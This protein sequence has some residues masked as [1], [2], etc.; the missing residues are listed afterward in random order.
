MS[1]YMR[2]ITDRQ[3]CVSPRTTNYLR[4][5]WFTYFR[6]SRLAGST[7]RWYSAS[8]TVQLN[9]GL[10]KLPHDRRA[11]RQHMSI[12]TCCMPSWLWLAFVWFPIITSLYWPRR[13]KGAC[14]PARMPTV[15][16]NGLERLLRRDHRGRHSTVKPSTAMTY[17]GYIEY[18]SWN[19]SSKY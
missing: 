6:R 15:T 19:D 14:L 7:S 18:R 17:I 1:D 5:R 13:S 8:I 16:G 4:R 9:I 3:S 10:V 11:C 2:H 12:I